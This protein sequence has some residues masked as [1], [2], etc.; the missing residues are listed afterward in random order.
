VN[1]ENDGMEKIFSR[2]PGEPNFPLPIFKTL[3]PISLC[4]LYDCIFPQEPHAFGGFPKLNMVIS[5]DLV[6]KDDESFIK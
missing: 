3:L 1:H 6:L 5:P 2:G 4:P